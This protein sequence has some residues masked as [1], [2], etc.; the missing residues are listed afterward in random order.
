MWLRTLTQRQ[1]AVAASR[2]IALFL[3]LTLGFPVIILGIAS[4]SG[5][6]EACGA[7]ALVISMFLKPL[8]VLV[9][10]YSMGSISLRRAR[11]AGL[12]AWFGLAVPAMIAADAGSA[13]ALGA[14]WSFTFTTGLF[15]MGYPH[16]LLLALACVVGL[17]I[18]GSDDGRSHR[19]RFGITGPAIA[20]LMA[21][22]GVLALFRLVNTFYPTLLGSMP[23]GALTSLWWA[24]N[25]LPLFAAVMVALIVIA[26]WMDRR[27]A[28]AA[29]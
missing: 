27:D 6:R 8:I 28:P 19:Q 18:V 23:R 16:F 20:W 7:M 4:A 21:P 15:R 26:I 13:L 22:V 25:L 3:L 1:Y 2:R 29:A 14:H 10:I 5:C 11:D 17:S 9:F 24:Y 12:A